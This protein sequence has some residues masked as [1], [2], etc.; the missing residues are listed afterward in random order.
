VIVDGADVPTFM[1]SPS[2]VGFALAPGEHF[3]VAE[4]RSTPIKAPLLALGAVVLAATVAASVRRRLAASP[5]RVRR[6]WR[7]LQAQWSQR[8]RRR[9]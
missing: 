5:E 1:A 7:S 2:Y 8:R 4:Y 6:L 9:D 3:I